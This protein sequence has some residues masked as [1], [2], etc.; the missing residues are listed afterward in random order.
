LATVEHT[1]GTQSTRLDFRAGRAEFSLFRYSSFRGPSSG[2]NLKREYR[3]A[4]NLTKRK[5]SGLK[6]FIIETIERQPLSQEF[7]HH[8]RWIN[9]LW[10]KYFGIKIQCA[11]ACSGP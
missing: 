7:I 9:A 10:D 3:S 5:T 2:E 11:D 4:E 1:Y 6:I 8:V